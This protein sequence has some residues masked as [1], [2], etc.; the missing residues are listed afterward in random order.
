MT[1]QPSKDTPPRRTRRKRLPELEADLHELAAEARE[2]LSR[3][4]DGMAGEYTAAD[5]ARLGT[6]WV[7]LA[8]AALKCERHRAA[9]TER[10]SR[11]ARQR[12]AAMGNGLSAENLS[13]IENQEQIL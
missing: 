1:G 9:E 2:L 3:I 6:L 12:E 10:K 8:E 5:Y 7:R 11:A 4:S 13:G